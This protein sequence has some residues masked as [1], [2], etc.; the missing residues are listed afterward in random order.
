MEKGA[1]GAVLDVQE[2]ESAQVRASGAE[3]GGTAQVGHKRYL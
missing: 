2:D 1:V 3:T